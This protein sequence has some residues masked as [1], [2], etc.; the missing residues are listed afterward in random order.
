MEE[1]DVQIFNPRPNKV[2]VVKHLITIYICDKRVTAKSQTH[3][4][5]SDLP[6]PVEQFKIIK[7]YIRKKHKIRL[8]FEY[9][10]LTQDIFS[11]E[12]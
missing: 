8:V 1:V 2:T 3:D 7:L 4:E 11:F 9:A 12:L 6:G 5:Q 10:M